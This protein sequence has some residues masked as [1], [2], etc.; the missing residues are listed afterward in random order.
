MA[1]GGNQ[2]LGGATFTLT[3][4]PQPFVQGMQQVH[5]SA[6]NTSMGLFALSGAVDDLQYGFNAIVNNIPHVVYMMGGSAGLAGA[7]GIAT[8][9]VNQLVQ[10]WDE[11]VDRMQAS[12][13]G[14]TIDQ[15]QKVREKADEASKAFDRLAE[16]PTRLQSKASQATENAI[17]ESGTAEVMKGL[18]ESIAQDPGMKASWQEGAKVA[19]WNSL[20]PFG[21]K[22]SIDEATQGLNTKKAQELLGQSRAPGAEGENARATIGRLVK[23]N[24]GAFPAGFAEKFAAGTPEAQKRQEDFEKKTDA[25]KMVQERIRKETEAKND[26]ME[27]DAKDQLRGPKHAEKD[28]KEEAEKAEKARRKA[29][30]ERD[31]GL[32]KGLEL[33]E[34]EIHNQRKLRNIFRK[35]EEEGAGTSDPLAFANKVLTGGVDKEQADRKRQIEIL[36]KI[37]DLMQDNAM[38]AK[39]DQVQAL[40]AGP[41]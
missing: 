31:R 4:N 1:T 39:R 17:T 8:V 24:P 21:K 6:R 29:K 2:N 18:S 25:H 23:K 27:Q 40:A 30:Q 7:V 28:A 9:A 11:L 3:A 36:E 32:Q 22:L 26:K 20:N 33:E 37:R 10:H 35:P 16:K 34:R 12:W 15:L 14:S 5:A 38:A 19:F 13:S 41:D